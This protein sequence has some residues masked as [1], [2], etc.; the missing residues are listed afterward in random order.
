[1]SGAPLDTSCPRCG[2]GFECG[3]NAGH[4]ACFGLRLS[5]TLRAELAARYP[6]RCLCLNCL[7]ELGAQEALT[8]PSRGTAA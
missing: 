6:D 5:E 3:V 1:M 7:R 2:G 4:C 8:P